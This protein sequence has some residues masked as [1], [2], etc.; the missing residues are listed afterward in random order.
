MLGDVFQNGQ[1]GGDR[2][3]RILALVE[4]LN[5]IESA[6][7]TIRY[8]NDLVTELPEVLRTLGDAKDAAVAALKTV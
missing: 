7:S 8:D 3:N 4:R 5:K 1:D 6:I 2:I